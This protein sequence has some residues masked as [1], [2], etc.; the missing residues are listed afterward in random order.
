MGSGEELAVE[1]T[2]PVSPAS[3]LAGSRAAPV[4]V[5]A[6]VTTAAAVEERAESR[7][8]AVE[9]TAESRAA[10]VEETAE[11]TAAAVEETAALSG[12]VGVGAAEPVDPFVDPFTIGATAGAV[13]ADG[14]A[15]VAFTLELAAVELSTL[16]MGAAAA[17]LQ[18]TA[19][20]GG[21][22]EVDDERASHADPVLWLSVQPVPVELDTVT[23][24]TSTGVISTSD[25][26]LLCV[27]TA[28]S[29][30]V[31]MSAAVLEL[32]E[33]A[34]GAGVGSCS[35]PLSVDGGSGASTAAPVLEVTLDD[36]AVESGSIP[37]QSPV[38]PATSSTITAGVEGKIVI[39]PVADAAAV[40]V[41]MTSLGTAASFVTAGC[42]FT[43]GIVSAPASSFVGGTISAPVSASSCCNSRR[44]LG[45]C[46]AAAVALVPVTDFGVTTVVSPVVALTRIPLSHGAS[47]RFEQTTR[48]AVGSA[49]Q[50]S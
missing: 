45:E 41:S 12:E 27:G 43:A 21:E 50:L 23:G 10:A 3:V 6:A 26:E 1:K 42:S 44:P 28:G 39:A 48:F 20:R 30:E 38:D 15:V 4:E 18:S 40:V 8:G 2:T 32:D 13:E 24:G 16:W 9:E 25:V 29:A 5:A 34:A 19:A 17:V 31:S 7:A 46:V 14:S 49:A 22:A 11:S 36:G 35:T 33:S 37:I 47:H